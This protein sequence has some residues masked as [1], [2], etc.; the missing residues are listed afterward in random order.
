[1][2]RRIIYLPSTN[3]LR[4][5]TI[6]SSMLPRGIVDAS[7]NDIVWLYH[8]YTIQQEWDNTY[9]HDAIIIGPGF[10]VSVNNDNLTEEIA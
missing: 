4:I 1:M 2:L 6:G 5:L 3:H 7:T 8:G 9:I 10:C